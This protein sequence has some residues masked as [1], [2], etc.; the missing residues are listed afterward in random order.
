MHELECHGADL[1]AMHGTLRQ[2][3]CEG[4]EGVQGESQAIFRHKTNQQRVSSL[5][6]N[7][8]LPSIIV[9]I[10]LLQ[11]SW[12]V[13]AKMLAEFQQIHALRREDSRRERV[14]RICSNCKQLGHN[15]R[16]C[17]AQ[18]QAIE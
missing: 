14:R 10:L 2:F 17:K 9:V 16:T 13:F 12:Q 11:Q 8:D 4:L 6:F 3:C 5:D 7:T 15:V 1:L 18:R